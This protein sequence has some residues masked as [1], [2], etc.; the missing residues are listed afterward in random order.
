VTGELDRA[1]MVARRASSMA[2]ACHAEPLLE[3]SS[4][5]QTER[6]FVVRPDVIEISGA[7]NT[8]T[9]SD[10]ERRVAT[11]AAQGYTNR[12]IARRLFI[13][14]STVEQHLTRA[15]R[16]LNV[17]RRTDLPIGIEVMTVDSA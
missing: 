17:N 5:R 11:L 10:A 1:R 6:H 9:L 14:V 16:K 2:K 15:Y 7:A 4:S 3:R 13:T 12:Q 8:S